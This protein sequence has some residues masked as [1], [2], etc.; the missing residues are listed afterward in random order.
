MDKVSQIL[1]LSKLINSYPAG[2]KSD[3]LCLEPGH[4]VDDLS[5]YISMNGFLFH[6]LQGVMESS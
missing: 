2:S 4:L 6:H 3:R 1:Y 5:S